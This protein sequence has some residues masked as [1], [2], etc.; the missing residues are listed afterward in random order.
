MPR[1]LLSENVKYALII[2]KLKPIISFS[3]A[4]SPNNEAKIKNV[5][6]EV[7]LAEKTK[8]INISYQEVKGQRLLAII[9]DY[10][11]YIKGYIKSF[12]K[13]NFLLAI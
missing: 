11:C 5:A 7:Y 2:I 12:S 4:D 6:K 8:G 1:Q 10:E 9:N 13:K 3:R